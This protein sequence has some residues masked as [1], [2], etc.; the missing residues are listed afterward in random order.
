MH[1]LMCNN[2]ENNNIELVETM[3]GTFYCLE[4][5]LISN[6]LKKFSAHTRNELSMLR[7]FIDSGDNIIDIGAHIGTFSIPFARFSSGQGKIFSIEGNPCNYDLL[8]R[9]I[10]ENDLEN[11]ILTKC[12]VVGSKGEKYR[13]VLPEKRNSGGCYFIQDPNSS[14]N[15]IDTEFEIE[16]WIKT[17]YTNLK[18]NLIKIDIEGAEV[19]ALRSCNNIIRKNLPIIYVEINKEALERAGNTIE[20]IQDILSPLDYHFFRNIGERNSNN[21]RFKIAKLGNVSRGG[22]FFDLMAV[23][24]FDPKYPEDYI[25]SWHFELIKLWNK[26]LNK[27]KISLKKS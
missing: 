21:D 20:D 22:S 6:Q 17:H 11:V 14:E 23:S 3:Y 27:V 18:I 19:K 1:T 2:I 10:K 13:M 16:E 24:K 4:G 9:N 5:D 7:N 8:V 12:H 25:G 15:L 26:V